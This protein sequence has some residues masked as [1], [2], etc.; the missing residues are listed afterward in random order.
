MPCVLGLLALATRGVSLYKFWLMMGSG[1]VVRRGPRSGTI[2]S[3]NRGGRRLDL[4]SNFESEASAD[5]EHPG[6]CRRRQVLSDRPRDAMAR[7]R[8]LSPLLLGVGHQ[9]RTG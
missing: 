3:V 5:G 8:D 9:E 4:L 2:G 6:S 7:R 1:V